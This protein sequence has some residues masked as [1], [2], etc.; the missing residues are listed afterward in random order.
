MSTATITEVKNRLSAIIDRVRSGE[1]VI[2]TDRGQPVARIEP[3]R[4]DSDATARITRL[5]RSGIIRAGVAAPPSIRAPV[6]VA[7]AS[8]VETLLDERRSGR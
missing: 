4:A 6:T 8:A 3:V 1:T 2:V 5:E 7:G